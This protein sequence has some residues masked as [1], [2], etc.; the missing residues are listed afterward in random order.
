MEVIAGTSRQFLL[1]LSKDLKVLI[2]EHKEDKKVSI[3]HLEE[4]LKD[5]KQHFWAFHGWGDI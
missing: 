5:I 2:A 1:D 3:E 4:M